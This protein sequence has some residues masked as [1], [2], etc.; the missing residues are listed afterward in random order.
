ML[1]AAAFGATFGVL[2][3]NQ[4]FSLA[5]TTAMSATTFAGSA[6]FGLVTVLDA[7]GTLAA[8]LLAAIVLN[9]RYLA[10]GI[11]IAPSLP[12]ATSRRLGVAA[13]LADESWALS[14]VG[15]GRYEPLRLVG[16]SLALFVAWVGGTFIGAL[17][18]DALGDPKAFGL[19]AVFPAVFLA[20]LAPHLRGWAGLV[21]ATACLTLALTPLVP[22][23]LPILGAMLL[24]LAWGGR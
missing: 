6:Q 5:A 19:D 17:A 21:A 9:A 18:G 10:Y 1:A 20:L 7:G 11:A 3:H 16:A 15:G 23:G 13:L 2:A 22:P 8:A 4:G 14:Y 24:A 12:R